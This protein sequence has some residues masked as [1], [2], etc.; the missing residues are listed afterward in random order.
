ML[1]RQGMGVWE[2]AVFSYLMVAAG[3]PQQTLY[4][5][6]LEACEAARQAVLEIGQEERPNPVVGLCKRTERRS[7]GERAPTLKQ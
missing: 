1:A 3:R 5:P 4:Y 6:T 7:L 2:L